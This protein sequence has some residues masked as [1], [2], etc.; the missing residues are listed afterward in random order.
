MVV[1]GFFNKRRVREKAQVVH[2][3]S[4]LPGSN[5]GG[6][7]LFVIDLPLAAPCITDEGYLNIPIGGGKLSKGFQCV[8]N[9]LLFAKRSRNENFYF[10][11]A[12]QFSGNEW[13]PVT[14]NTQVLNPYLSLR[15][16]ELNERFFI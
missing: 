1:F 15:A 7:L 11:I 6:N 9:A 10:L 13:Y 3:L 16:A 5:E 8:G 2:S 4:Y 14:I 12:P